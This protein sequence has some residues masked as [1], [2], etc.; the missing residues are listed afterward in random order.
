MSYFLKTK[1]G[2]KITVE[3]I[4][5]IHILLQDLSIN[6]NTD[7]YDDVTGTY[8][9]VSDIL[10]S[11]EINLYGNEDF[12][13]PGQSG[14]IKVQK[15]TKTFIFSSIILVLDLLLL[16][17]NIYYYVHKSE[18]LIIGDISIPSILIFALSA[19]LFILFLPV[20]LISKSVN[21]KAN[22]MVMLSILLF[23]FMTGQFGI[24]FNTIQS[25]K[26]KD[27]AAFAYVDSIIKD[28]LQDKKPQAVEF[29]NEEYGDYWV[30]LKQIDEA[31]VEFY[32][33]KAQY[34]DLCIKLAANVNDNA[35]AKKNITEILAN[36]E[37]YE[38]NYNRFLENFKDAIENSNIPTNQKEKMLKNYYASLEKSR[39]FYKEYFNIAKNAYTLYDK[40]VQYRI[41][42]N[43]LFS[44]NYNS[45]IFNVQEKADK[46][47]SMQS[48]LNKWINEEKEWI[49]KRDSKRKEII[50]SIS[51]S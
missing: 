28:M 44:K 30:M 13:F 41:I 42:N 5:D 29:D 32:N 19:A 48:E 10:S 45:F 20:I 6:Y 36:L 11:N 8:L 16:T 49:K 3:S 43:A 22:G 17:F 24:E 46:Y 23:M 40:L 4:R 27:S 9:K 7:V 51:K 12:D 38:L 18:N 15:R 39:G 34:V 21:V 1:Y 37:N 25:E 31:Y 26:E 47:N 14:Y 33:S 2:T 35:A 50:N